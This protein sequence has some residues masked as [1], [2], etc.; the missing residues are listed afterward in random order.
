MDFD[1]QAY[2][3]AQKGSDERPASVP[4]YA[5]GKDRRVMR[6]LRL[7]KPVKLAIDAG[8]RFARTL[9]EQL[10]ERTRVADRSSQPRLL[11][12][13]R[14]AS[15]KLGTRTP[16]KVLVGDVEGVRFITA[17]AHR[18]EELLVVHPDVLEL[19][20]AGLAFHV[21]RAVG[22]LQQGHAVYLNA[23]WVLDREPGR[24]TGWIVGPA[25]AETYLEKPES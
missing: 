8:M 1:F 13:V 9:F 19:D 4:G 2:I 12:V 10:A 20:D 17:L 23:L 3:R 5:F 11:S 21:G 16:S 14:D 6:T 25:T 22:H 24:V 15:E 7:A 18:G